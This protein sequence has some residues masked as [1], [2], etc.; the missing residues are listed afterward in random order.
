[1]TAIFFYLLA[2]GLFGL[3]LLLIRHTSPYSREGGSRFEW[4]M[5]RRLIGEVL[6][7]A[8]ILALGL[9]VVNQLFPS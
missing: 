7:L 6:I 3:G 2:L 8:S 9:A 5:R 4:K 1:M